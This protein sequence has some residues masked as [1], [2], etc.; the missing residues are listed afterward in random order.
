LLNQ[1]GGVGG[2]ERII[3]SDQPNPQPRTGGVPAAACRRCSEPIES[4][5]FCDD[6]CQELWECEQLLRVA[7]LLKDR[8]AASRRADHGVLKTDANLCAW[9][10]AIRAMASNVR[11]L[12]SRLELAR[13]HGDRDDAEATARRLREVT[14][15]LA[16]A[17]CEPETQVAQLA[18]PVCLDDVEPAPGV[19]F[20]RV[21]F[22]PLANGADLC[23]DRC[24]GTYQ[25]LLPEPH[26][27]HVYTQPGHRWLA[28]G[29]PK[30]RDPSHHNYRRNY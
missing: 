17:K 26:V 25:R 22:A 27:E 28:P 1:S 6:D 12:E 7:A 24:R 23:G 18:N 8:E 2:G 4:G 20:C 21:C 3:Q 29:R 5:D 14:H 19:R 16:A 13:V 15:E 30:P 11:S 9:L 10:P